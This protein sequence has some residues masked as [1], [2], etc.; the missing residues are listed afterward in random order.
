MGESFD[1]YTLL[2][3]VL[4]VVIFL[5]LRNVLGRRTG[6]ERPPYDPYSA[7]DAKPN[8][9]KPAEQDKI[10]PLPGSRG[11][12]GE[13]AAADDFEDKL[14]KYG[15]KNGALAKGLRAIGGADPAFDPDHFLQ[16]A[17]AAYEMIV[18]AF[19]EGNKRSLRQL[20]NKD[21]Y[22]GFVGAI[23]ER[24]ERDEAVETSFV[25]ID[26]ADIVEAELK[27]SS[28]QV[29]V[30]FVSELITATR[31]KAGKVIDGDPKKVREV[32]D[33]WT[34]ARDTSSRDPNWK[35]VATEAAN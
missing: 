3:L 22:D 4:A 31:D 20:L 14:K 8:G 11:P 24:E 16:G 27:K 17:K 23:S 19:A 2:F 35:L 10:I 15:P 18:M 32:T 12:A 28:A 13:A 5:R 6:S 21:V 1:I 29:T 30:K 34:F 25:G 7:P 26:K 33:I 9:S